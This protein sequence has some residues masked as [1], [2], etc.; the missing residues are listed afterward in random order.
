M[1][2]ARNRATSMAKKAR[3]GMRRMRHI[4]VDMENR[5]KRSFGSP[6]SQRVEIHYQG[7]PFNFK[8]TDRMETISIDV[9]HK[10]QEIEKNALPGQSGPAMEVE[11]FD[12]TKR[13]MDTSTAY[14]RCS[15][16]I[17]IKGT[18]ATSL[19][20][21]QDGKLILNGIQ[22]P[23]MKS[24]VLNHRAKGHEIRLA[25]TD[26]MVEIIQETQRIKNFSQDRVNFYRLFP[27]KTA[28]VK[29]MASYGQDLLAEAPQY[30]FSETGEGKNYMVKQ[31]RYFT[32]F[33]VGIMMLIEYLSIMAAYSSEISYTT[34]PFNSVW[35]VVIAVILVLGGAMWRLHIYDVSNQFIKYIN[36]Q[37][38]PF[39]IGNRGIL[40]VVM[41]NSVINPVWDYQAKMMNLKAEAAT[42]VFH[43][44]TVWSDEQI[45]QLYRAKI[46][47]NVEHELSVLNNEMSDMRKVD[48]EYRNKQE[49]PQKPM[50]LLIATIFITAVATFLITF[51]L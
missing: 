2:D 41:T 15:C 8:Y 25:H 5:M 22:E 46:I 38:A 9:I 16:G 51:F 36:L 43:S 18:I 7:N 14:F 34:A 33:I 50:T 47:G 40:P 45:A 32:V 6:V 13:R 30:K 20:E 3:D 39:Y 35:Y 49:K 12:P 44:L 48:Y 21:S 11:Q 31:N 37:A 23:D 29:Y 26:S 42:D 19:V 24:T 28:D 4:S 17:K 10:E 27:T 1:A